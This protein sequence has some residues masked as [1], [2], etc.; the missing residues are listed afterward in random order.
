MA[1]PL[2][3][4]LYISINLGGIR[5]KN[6]KPLPKLT[7]KA[8]KQKNG[9][10]EG[11]EE[12]S[13][14]IKEK[15]FKNPKILTFATE[16]ESEEKPSWRDLEKDIQEAHPKLKILYSRMEEKKG[17]IA[18][19]SHNIDEEAIKSLL[20]SPFT[21]AGFEYKFGT[22]SDEDLK[23]FWDDH[24]SHY[25]MVTKQKM[26]RLKKR[27]R[28]ENKDGGNHKIQKTEDNSKSFTLA[29]TTYA[30]INKVKSKAKAIMNIKED[31]QK[32]EG[33]EEEFL[34]EI[35]K[36]HE[37]HEQKM[38]DFSHFIVDEHPSYQNTR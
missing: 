20:D 9:E 10:E 5:R 8:K 33:Y 38:T 15:D 17:Q 18:I 4:D 19:S 23:K 3:D 35:I 22:P 27:K 32:L 25:D 24:G 21:S 31:G 34:K 16:T 37:K 36:Y 26:R 12:D 28:E 14:E 11:K 13:S 1:S 7:L 6:N 2:F 29:G 30:N